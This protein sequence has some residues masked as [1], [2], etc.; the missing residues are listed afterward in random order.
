MP[1]LGVRFM[2]FSIMI[3]HN[4]IFMLQ[5]ILSSVRQVSEMKS[6]RH[7][8]N[9]E[10]DQSDTSASINRIAVGSLRCLKSVGLTFDMLLEF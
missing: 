7:F 4:I 9:G 8:S 5:G 6:E 2:K 10:V 1:E 3:S